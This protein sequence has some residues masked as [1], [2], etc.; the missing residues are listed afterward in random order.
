MPMTICGRVRSATRAPALPA[1]AVGGA[2]R[3]PGPGLL[4]AVRTWLGWMPPPAARPV[5]LRADVP[6]AASGPRT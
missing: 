5:P 6:A 3:R 1:P 4:A 2:A